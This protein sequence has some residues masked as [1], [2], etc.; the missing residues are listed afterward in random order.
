MHRVPRA[1]IDSE[2][3]RPD[4]AMA[5]RYDDFLSSGFLALQYPSD[6]DASESWKAVVATAVS[7]SSALARQRST[8]ESVLRQVLC[9]ACRL[10]IEISI[11]VLFPVIYSLLPRSYLAN[12]QFGLRRHHVRSS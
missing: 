6:F 2:Y 1:I 12:K 7:P 10:A 9:A 4:G 11:S 5:T 3:L 8:V